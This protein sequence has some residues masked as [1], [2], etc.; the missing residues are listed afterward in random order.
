MSSSAGPPKITSL[1]RFVLPGLFVLA[2]F[3]ALVVRRPEATPVVPDTLELSGEIMGTTWGARIRGAD[4]SEGAAIHARIQSSL[5]EVDASMSTWKEDSE[6]SRFNRSQSTEPITLSPLLT[7][8]LVAALEVHTSSAGAFD[9]TVGPLVQAW[10]FGSGA[11]RTPPDPAALDALKSRVGMGA[12]TLNEAARTIQKS[13][14]D[15][16]L[17]LSAIAKGFAVDRASEALIAGGHPHF[18][19]EVGGE[20]RVGGRG[21]G[22]PWRVAIEEPDLE[23]RRVREVLDMEHG[24]LATSGDYRQ[25]RMHEGR[26]VSHAI[27]P[28]TGEPVS[29]GVASVSV[30]AETAMEADAFATAFMVLGVEQSLDCA[31][32][33]GLD[34][35]L[36]V[37]SPDGTLSVQESPGFGRH[38][39]GRAGGEAP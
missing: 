12:L 38:R 35:Q 28:R 20:V 1:R 16:T 18:L 7:E 22:P 24:A 15:R 3:V 5:A 31:R 30:V 36:I 11:L 33:K 13:V 23:G 26:V 2:L 39:S 10:G 14:G 19:L 21:E 6:V 27:D 25:F 29:N 37:R 32:E 4:A 34:V 17:D 9:V 8:V